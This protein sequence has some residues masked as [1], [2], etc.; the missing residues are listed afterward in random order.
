VITAGA[1]PRLRGGILLRY[2]QVRE[3]HV[4][5]YPEGVLVLNETAA[6]IVRHCDGAATIAQITT[7]LAECY[8]G[9]RDTDVLEVLA[10]LVDRRMIEVAADG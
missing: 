3:R 10:R 6:A 8:R 2:D 4:L 7:A 9:V 5:M 1:R